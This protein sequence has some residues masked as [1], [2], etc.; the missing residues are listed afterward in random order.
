MLLS[1]AII[2]LRSSTSP[3]LGSLAVGLTGSLKQ[4]CQRTSVSF[5]DWAKL[6]AHTTPKKHSRVSRRTRTA[7]L[8]RLELL[9]KGLSQLLVPRVHC[10][11]EQVRFASEECH[12]APR[13]SH[14]SEPEHCRKYRKSTHNY[15]FPTL[16]PSGHDHT[17]DCFRGQEGSNGVPL[18][19]L[20][21]HPHSPKP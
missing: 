4:R 15:Q 5:V 10:G 3:F 13:E 9:D 18:V 21:A 7:K 16:H 2:P 17:L 1:W 14:H 19:H 20:L 8:H 12:M 11:R 6:A